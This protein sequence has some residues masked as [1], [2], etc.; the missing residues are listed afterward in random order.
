VRVTLITVGDPTRRTGGYRYHARL[1]SRLAARGISARHVVAG[2]ADPLAQAAAATRLLGL[3]DDADVVVI[4]ALA[5]IAGRPWMTHR[6][7]R[8]VVALV[9]ELPSCAEPETADPVDE[10]ALLGC[11][12]LVAVSPS[13]RDTLTARGVPVERI[14]IVSPGY[15]RHC[16][17]PV[18]DRD[19]GCVQVLCVAQWIRRKGIVELLRAW[20]ARERP[21]ARLVLVG[22][23]D[24]DPSYAAEV[25]ALLTDDIEVLGSVDDAVVA[26]CY[27]RA[28]V[29][30]LPSAAE[31]YGI[32]YAEALACGLPVLACTVGPVPDLVGEGGILVPPH[33]HEALVAALDTVLTD[34][35]LRDRL[36]ANARRRARSL[37]TWDDCADAFLAVLEEAAR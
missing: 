2:P 13:V 10:E 7:G 36:A 1:L 28:S 20:H 19:R 6:A 9:H 8:P 18:L 35:A 23:T 26:A 30:A 17:A 32:V 31:G 11:D 21:G 34:S 4:D 14:R 3:E 12:L 25:R 37:P 29:F 5:R 24:A 27:A 15:D 22:E 16:G 33:D